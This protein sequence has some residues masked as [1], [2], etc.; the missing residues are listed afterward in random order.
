MNT[1]MTFLDIFRQAIAQNEHCRLWKV[2]SYRSSI[3]H[4]MSILTDNKHPLIKFDGMELVS[5]GCLYLYGAD[6]NL[7][8]QI[9]QEIKDCHP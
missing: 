3:C 4:D 9:A 7:S 1:L 5:G 8:R 6:G 2:L